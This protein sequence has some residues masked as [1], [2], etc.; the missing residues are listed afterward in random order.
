MVL[1]FR[2]KRLSELI[3]HSCTHIAISNYS[4]L[5]VGLKNIPFTYPHIHRDK[6]QIHISIKFN[7]LYVNQG[8]I[9]YSFFCVWLCFIIVIGYNQ[10]I[11]ILETFHSFKYFQ[12][13]IYLFWLTNKY[14]YY[15]VCFKIFNVMEKSFPL[16]LAKVMGSNLRG[17]SNF[18]LILYNQK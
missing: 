12:R 11:L 7:C 1:I 4:R 18:C 14:Y 6:Y 16:L 13:N 15:S 9:F 8:W 10:D 3:Y 5:L 17:F 2:R